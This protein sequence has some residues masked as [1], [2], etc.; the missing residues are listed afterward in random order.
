MA[1][2]DSASAAVGPAVDWEPVESVPVVHSSAVA[3]AAGV[4]LVAG[5]MAAAV[6]AAAF[7]A[8]AVAFDAPAYY[9]ADPVNSNEELVV[10]ASAAVAAYAELEHDHLASWIA[11]VAAVASDG[12][13]TSF[14]EGQ[15]LVGVVARP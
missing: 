1:C 15:Q 12:V 4:G 8:E 5:A 13:A 10:A 2:S 7:V 9:D 14:S 11:V 6:V 3:A